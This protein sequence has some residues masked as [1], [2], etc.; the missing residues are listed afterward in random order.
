M[1]MVR[2][3]W[4]RGDRTVM[5]EQTPRTTRGFGTRRRGEVP[6]GADVS[7]TLGEGE[8]RKTTPGF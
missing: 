5:R 3:V 8:I 2:T 7:V 1:S 4:V 6:G